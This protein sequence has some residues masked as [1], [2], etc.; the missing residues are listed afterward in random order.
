MSIIRNDFRVRSHG[1]ITKQ[2]HGF[3][4]T[5]IYMCNHIDWLMGKK[6]AVGKSS[7][8]RVR[9]LRKMRVGKFL[10]VNPLCSSSPTVTMPGRHGCLSDP[11]H[12]LRLFSRERGDPACWSFSGA[13]KKVRDRGESC[14]SFLENVSSPSRYNTAV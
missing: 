1:P 14:S 10:I 11:R 9:K 3:R 12:F 7:V 6:E 2:S 8:F 5:Y 13:G 4:S